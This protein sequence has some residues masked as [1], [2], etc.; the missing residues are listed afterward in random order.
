MQWLDKLDGVLDAVLQRNDDSSQDFDTQNY[1]DNTNGNDDDNDD[2]A[3]QDPFDEYELDGQNV[4]L[5]GE[6]LAYGVEDHNLVRQQ[7]YIGGLPRPGVIRPVLREHS[8]DSSFAETDDDDDNGDDIDDDNDNDDGTQAGYEKSSDALKQSRGLIIQ[9]SAPREIQTV[10]Q[11]PVRVS[12][13][14]APSQTIGQ[15]KN[16]FEHFNSV[17]GETRN[18]RIKPRLPPPYAF[19]EPIHSPESLSAKQTNGSQL[20]RRGPPPPPL[21]KMSYISPPPPPPPTPTLIGY[22][23]IIDKD[24]AGKSHEALVVHDVNSDATDEANETTYVDLAENDVNDGMEKKVMNLIDAQPIESSAVATINDLVLSD[25]DNNDDDDDD[26]DTDIVPAEF[27]DMCHDSDDNDLNDETLDDDQGEDTASAVVPTRNEEIIAIKVDTEAD[28]A[29]HPSTPASF[30][31]SNLFSSL[32]LMPPSQ[33]TPIPTISPPALVPPLEEEESKVDESRLNETI[34]L[35][36][37]T[38]IEANA[39]D[40]E[41][42][43][44]EG[45]QASFGDFLPTANFQEDTSEDGSAM[46]SMTDLEGIDYIIDSPISWDANLEADNAPKFEPKMNCHGVLHV[47]LLRVQHLPCSADSSLQAIFSLPPWKGRIRSENVVTYK[48]PSK[49]GI[50]A[51]WDKA[52]KKKYNETEKD[53]DLDPWMDNDENEGE[54]EMACISMVHTYNSEDTPVPNI[55]IE[56]KDLALMFEREVCSLTLSCEPLM[57]QPG[58]FLQRWCS[59]ADTSNATKP[60]TREDGESSNLAPVPIFLVEACFEPTNFGETQ[61]DGGEE[62]DFETE[63]ID[64]MAYE[65]EARDRF[66][67]HHDTLENVSPTHSVKTKLSLRQASK[68]RLKLRP[69]MFINYSSLRPTYCALCNTMIVWKLKGYQCE[70][71]RLDCCA[72]C[73]LRVDVDLPCGSEK[74][75]ESVKKLSESKFTLSKIYDAVAPKKDVE[76]EPSSIKMDLEK[77]TRSSRETIDWRDGVGTFTIRIN[78]GCLFRHCFPPETDLKHILEASDRWLRSGDYYTRVSW[79]DST[80]TRRTKTVFQSA[81]PRFDSD[82]IVI[83]SSHYGTE[84]K[85]EVVDGSTDQAI[86]SKLLTTQGLLQWQRDNVGW[87]LSLNSVMNEEPVRLERRTVCFELRTNVKTG[88]GLDFYNTGKV[89][90][91]ARTGKH[92]ISIALDLVLVCV[93]KKTYLRICCR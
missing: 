17:N 79:T 41:Y 75:K 36:N 80:K 19:P 2:N 87:C 26:D 81:K 59:A 90:E 28:A 72:D 8:D 54:N 44:L 9:T 57:S 3:N 51:R 6:S 23:K 64:Q 31:P 86:G 88:F 33:A 83:T 74:A 93:T 25:D 70:I 77:V 62:I 52:K 76:S 66:D 58:Q 13:L 15:N 50:C 63:V 39:T 21:L 16:F 30:I 46:T 20:E 24:N 43:A 89:S 35:A 38:T 69:H 47:K 71:C 56:L 29:V 14:S 37:D 65:G 18:G 73:Q 61:S 82:D 84:F 91:T 12:P 48:G 60:K 92:V 1:Y 85:I 78:K 53:E 42:N 10:A 55:S 40:Y 27:I 67:T 34:D 49:A 45:I 7:N 32:G 68:R 22:A 5:D 11:S 4:E